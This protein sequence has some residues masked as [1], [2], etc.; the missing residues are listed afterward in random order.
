VYLCEI[1]RKPPSW[2]KKG[3]KRGQLI[4]ALAPECGGSAKKEFACR[5]LPQRG[6]S[7]GRQESPQRWSR[8]KG[9]RFALGLRGKG[10]KSFLDEGR[11]YDCL[12][13]RWT[14]E[15]PWKGK[16]ATTEGKKKRE[17]ARPK[18]APKKFPA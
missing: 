1:K 8:G 13:K 12:S 6:L 4:P 16:A 9:E 18:R 14:L 2:A 7:Y 5:L 10:K 15:P 3:K 17:G 11:T